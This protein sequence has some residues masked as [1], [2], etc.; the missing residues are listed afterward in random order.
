MCS[1]TPTVSEDY[2]A[3]LGV[4][5]GVLDGQL[6][7]LVNQEAGEHVALRLDHPAAPVSHELRQRLRLDLESM[8]RADLP[9][10]QQRG[11]LR[12]LAQLGAKSLERAGAL[13]SFSDLRDA[14]KHTGL[15][16][17]GVQYQ[18]R[19]VKNHEPL[20][21]TQ[22]CMVIKEYADALRSALAAQA[23]GEVVEARVPFS[24]RLAD[25]DYQD[26]DPS[27]RPTAEMVEKV[28]AEVARQRRAC[29]MLDMRVAPWHSKGAKE[30]T[31]REIVYSEIAAQ[32]SGIPGAATAEAQVAAATAVHTARLLQQTEQPAVWWHSVTMAVH[33]LVL[34]GCMGPKAMPVAVAYLA[35]LSNLGARY[36]TATAIAY[37]KALRSRAAETE[38]LRPSDVRALFRV[39]HERTMAE[40]T[41]DNVWHHG[42]GA[43]PKP[44]RPPPAH[45]AQFPQ[46]Q[47]QQ[48][49]QQ[50][51]QQQQQQQ[52]RGKRRRESRD[53]RHAPFDSDG[54]PPP[55]G[56]PPA[57]AGNPPPRGGGGKGKGPNNKGSGRRG[58]QSSN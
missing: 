17:A 10:Q 12:G 36:N 39:Q 44:P 43:G 41:T 11:L 9:V 14:L 8:G 37:D 33:S 29:P 54:L 16:S 20:L 53:D 25:H 23:K 3:A 4:P 32:A 1:D 38:E 13:G 42:R 35:Q 49:Q 26:M 22:E 58:G 24:K 51:Q 46:Q 18:D 7:L 47:Q 21:T 56:P 6:A 28:L 27:T 57:L 34:A 45:G 30:R 55:P 15:P 48:Q 2:A 52:H 50:R 19:L 40:L 5:K 31:T